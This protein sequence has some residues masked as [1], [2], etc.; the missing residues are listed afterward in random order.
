MRVNSLDVAECVRDGVECDEYRFRRSG[1]VRQQ[2]R[3]S[4]AVNYRTSQQHSG[5]TKQT[6]LLQTAF[7]A[8]HFLPIDPRKSSAA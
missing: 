8:A 7:I 3:M 5:S 4:T 1:T 2:L 6:Q